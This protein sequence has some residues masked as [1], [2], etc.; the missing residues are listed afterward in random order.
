[1]YM[2]VRNVPAKKVTKNIS[3]VF[4][5]LLR[6]VFVKLSQALVAWW[7]WS[8]ARGRLVM[9]SSPCVPMET[10]RVEGL[11]HVKSVV[12]QCPHEGVV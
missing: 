12:A 8:R 6:L 3:L 5:I 9:S 10:R 4:P 2:C 11:M 7:S 1:M